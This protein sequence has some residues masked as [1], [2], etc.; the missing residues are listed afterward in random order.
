MRLYKYDNIKSLLI[1]LVVLGHCIRHLISVTILARL[2]YLFIFLFHMP[3][4]IYVLGRF[5]KPKW[6]KAA[7]YSVLYV[8][9]QLIYSIFFRLS[10]LA[11][12]NISLLTPRWIIW[13]LQLAAI[14]SV[15][16]FIIPS[17]LSGKQKVIGITSSFIV[18]LVVGFIPFIAQTFSIS[19][20]FVFFPF[21]LMGKWRI[22]E[23]SNLFLQKK[24][25]AQ[26]VFIGTIA[27][28]SSFVFC[29]LSKLNY[30]MLYQDTG[31]EASSSTWTLRFFAMITAVLWIIFLLSIIPNKKIP[32][33]TS[34]GAHTLFIYLFHGFFVKIIFSFLFPTLNLLC[35]SIVAVILTV[36]LYFLALLFAKVRSYATKTKTA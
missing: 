5:S 23:N 12:D 21:F 20:V 22:G 36:V 3:A 35:S 14:Y 4:F 8:C 27:T 30:S 24:R 31:Y 34:V 13:F 33:V 32:L 28:I 9:F 29:V 6:K 15:L 25:V 11:N 10:G 18:A 26:T 19:R 2:L 7:Y 16:S 17:S 1:F